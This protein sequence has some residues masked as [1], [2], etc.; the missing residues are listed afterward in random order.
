MIGVKRARDHDEVSEEE[1]VVVVED[2]FGEEVS[3]TRNASAMRC[4]CSASRRRR[5]PGQVGQASSVS[6]SLLH[7]PFV[8]CGLSLN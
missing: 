4:E 3:A 1:E 5:R 6:V 2:E 7:P 8:P